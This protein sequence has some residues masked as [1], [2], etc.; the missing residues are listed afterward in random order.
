[1]ISDYGIQ[2]APVRRDKAASAPKRPGEMYQGVVTKAYPDGRIVIY[3]QAL[4]ISY[5]PLMPLGV[6]Q[7][8][9]M[10]IDDTV[11]CAFSNQAM[12]SMVVFGNARPINQ[13]MI[14]IM[15][16]TAIYPEV[17]AAL[18]EGC[19]AYATDTNSYF[20]WDGE[21]WVSLWSNAQPVEAVSNGPLGASAAG[22][23]LYNT[24]TCTLE[25]NSSTGF[26]IGQKVDFARRATGTF[27]IIPGAG[28][29]V[30]TARSLSLRARYSV[31]TLVCVDLNSYLLTGDLT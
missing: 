14:L 17:V 1:M 30:D 4:G 15:E 31:A 29:S 18:P 20:L 25:I 11:L 9:K 28:V 19:L 2:N 8:T 24:T 13:S 6:T 27:T 12:T 21:S 10:I 5:G 3:V 7:S 22:K 26:A 23:L 16:S